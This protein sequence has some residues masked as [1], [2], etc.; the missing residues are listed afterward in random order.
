MSLFLNTLHLKREM[1]DLETR[2][3][4][5]A[6]RPYLLHVAK[7]AIST[8]PK[9]ISKQRFL[10]FLKVKSWHSWAAQLHSNS[11]T[12]DL[13]FG[14][15]STWCGHA[16][17]RP[18]FVARRKKVTCNFWKTLPN[19][20]FQTFSGKCLGINFHLDHIPTQA[21]LISTFWFSD[22]WCGFTASRPPFLLHV[23]KK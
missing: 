4:G 5:S 21:R 9:Y 7:K 6:A 12:I 15:S 10:I 16:A 14:Y 22:T 11:R 23:A 3:M 13:I 2:D 19:D 1:R 17:V 18:Y 8:F 20:S